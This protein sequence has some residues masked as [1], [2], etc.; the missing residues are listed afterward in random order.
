MQGQWAID[1]E[2]TVAEARR[3]GLGEADIV[4]V[5]ELYG[6]G[7][8]EITEDALVMRVA[9]VSDSVARNY[10]VLDR[11][12]DCYRLEVQGA[13]QHPRYCLQAGRLI[14]NDPGAML[15]LVFKRS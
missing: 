12:G 8:L 7:L 9:G 15:S 11:S 10:R 2:A 4:Q 1:L 6:R 14:V 13:A 5:G 3:R